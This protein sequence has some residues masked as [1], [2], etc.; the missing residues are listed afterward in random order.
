V[1]CASVLDAAAQQATPY[2][3][4]CCPVSP[5]FTTSSYLDDAGI[6]CQP[7]VRCHTNVPVCEYL[8]WNL[9]RFSRASRCCVCSRQQVCPH[10]PLQ[11]GN[12]ASTRVLSIR[13][14]F[15]TRVC[16]TMGFLARLAPIHGATCLSNS[17]PPCRPL[18]KHACHLS[19]RWP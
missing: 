14:E 3:C 2:A 8:P 7:T 1:S 15:A 16:A 19:A 4:K 13:E 11:K 18:C 6:A 9:D 10:K 12:R 17:T 5:G